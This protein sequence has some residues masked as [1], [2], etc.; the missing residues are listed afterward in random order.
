MIIPTRDECLRLLDKYMGQEFAHITKHSLVVEK[1][2]VFLAKKLI[3]AGEEVNL[4]LA[5]RIA[6]LHDIGKPEEIRVTLHG[7]GHGELGYTTLTKEG[8]PEIGESARKHILT[9]LFKEK[10]FRTWSW[11]ELITLYADQR[12]NNDQIVTVEERFEYFNKRYGSL[13]PRSMTFFELVK[14]KVYA[15]EKHIFDRIDVDPEAVLSLT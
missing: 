9:Y 11:E 3:A 5:S 8:Y 10:D 15:I 6:M 13:S 14:P 12:V 1:I 2:V 7:S 4:D